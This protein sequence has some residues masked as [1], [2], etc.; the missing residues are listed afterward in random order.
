V[1]SNKC[2]TAFLAPEFWHSK[3]SYERR[4]SQYRRQLGWAAAWAQGNKSGTWI[5]NNIIW[6]FARMFDTYLTSFLSLARIRAVVWCL[7]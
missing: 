2:P 6:N 1:R 7:K 4:E 5:T 3:R